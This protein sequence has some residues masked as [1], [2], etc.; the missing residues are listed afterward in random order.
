MS[1][2]HL[3]TTVDLLVSANDRPLPGAFVDI[4]LPTE[5]KNNYRFPVGPADDDGRLRVSGADLAGWARRT[6]DLFLM[7]YSGLE[8]NWTGEIIATPTNRAGL[9]RLRNAHETWGHTGIYPETFLA[10][11]DRLAVTLDQLPAQT[12]LTV[13]I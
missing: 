2:P 9:T 13:A 1:Q 7:D 11:L 12:S 5:R 4:E 10:D 8:G 6:N 3:P